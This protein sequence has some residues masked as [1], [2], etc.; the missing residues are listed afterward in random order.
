MKNKIETLIIK[1]KLVLK[2]ISGEKIKNICN[3]LINY[4]ICNKNLTYDGSNKHST[5]QILYSLYKNYIEFGLKGLINMQ[6]K[7]KQNKN[8]KKTKE[9]LREELLKKMLEDENITKD[10]LIDI[11]DI[12]SK[13]KKIEI[14][15]EFLIEEIEKKRKKRK[16]SGNSFSV[17]LICSLIGISRSYFYQVV[18]KGYSKNKIKKD[19]R[20]RKDKEKIK[21]MIFNIWFS[22][23]Q[24]YGVSKI[25][26]TIND[27][28]KT[29]ISHKTVHKYMVE[30]GIKSKIRLKNS[31]RVDYKNTKDNT[32]NLLN[33]NF[34]VHPD[35]KTLCT[36]V[37]FLK[38]NNYFI[39]LSGA[40]DL[41]NNMVVGHSI[42]KR[43]DLNLVMET[44]KKI[45]LSNYDMVHSDHGIQYTS[46]KFKSML[47]ENNIKQSMSE[48][49]KSLHNR[50][51][52]YFWSV[53]KQEYWNNIDTSNLSYEEICKE[54]TN[55]IK[56]YNFER[57][58][59][60]LDGLTP[61]KYSL[62]NN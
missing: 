39:Y 19:K 59:I 57:I 10:Y 11:I 60:V 24:N 46:S 37:T 36:D 56:R 61:A 49:G 6:G 29:S 22:S 47:I 27:K 62:I 9:E 21:K 26:K 38:V 7:Q 1:L 35:N 41:R 25:K 42:S 3:E 32:P 52:E 8:N 40:I 50:P 51:I 54:I 45:D 31:R 53:F 14:D 18:E 28:Y 55:A 12:I 33:Q 17:K 16:A 43:N 23:N 48:V 13:V 30:L 34:E 4:K 5:Y 58:Q 44:F 20:V 15:K 2:I